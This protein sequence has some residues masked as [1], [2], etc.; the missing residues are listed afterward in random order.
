ME[1]QKHQLNHLEEITH[2]GYGIDLVNHM[3]E[4]KTI[5]KEDS[6]YLKK[7]FKKTTEN[8]DDFFN[9]V[10]K[11]HKLTPY[12]N[13]RKEIIYKDEKKKKVNEYKIAKY[14]INL[15]KIKE[16]E[17]LI[18]NEPENIIHNLYVMIESTEMIYLDMEQ[19][20]RL[21]NINIIENDDEKILCYYSNEKFLE[22]DEAKSIISNNLKNRFGLNISSIAVVNNQFVIENKKIDLTPDFNA[23]NI[24][25]KINK[26]QILNNNKRKL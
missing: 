17:N 13:Y 3:L 20:E 15:L 6:V 5:K 23:N 9:I 21:L 10:L 8:I 11:A 14:A 7:I 22:I 1:K 2:F 16:I 18:K 26:Q 19:A 4:L 24:L 25:D 12:S